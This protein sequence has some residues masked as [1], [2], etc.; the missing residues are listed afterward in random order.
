VGG[1]RMVYL[2][3]SQLP[4]ATLDKLAGILEI[5]EKFTGQDP[6]KVPMVIF[7]AVHYTMGGLYTVY[8]P[9]PD[10]KGLVPGA[11][12]NMMT[13]VAGLYA[14]GE[15]NYQ[16]HGATRLGA[17]ALLS[18]IFD[19]LFC[20]LSVANY[21]KEEAQAGEAPG[22]LLEKV[23]QQEKLRERRLVEGKGEHNP[24]TIHREL[25][26][27]MTDECT[28]VRTEEGMKR[29][30]D[31]LRRLKEQYTSIK[32]S[33]TGTWT[34]QTLAFGRTLGDMLVY[35]EAI[36]VAALARRESR[37]AHYRSDYPQRDDANFLKTTIAKYDE[38]GD[39]HT[40]VFEDV[41][42]PLVKPR[43]R[44]YGKADG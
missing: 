7:P 29:A 4:G 41:P 3:V 11:T 17:N 12:N 14:F 6:R 39:R 9:Q 1:G 8:T 18:C 44:T 35:A 26:E 32:L 31:V 5:Y 23:V 19:G 42:T 28:V 27:V 37:G 22:S 24:F 16:Y 10:S 30:S 21:A 20:G 13:N 43:A 25:G 15:V 33:D 34:N 36:L 38:A 2:D 40:L